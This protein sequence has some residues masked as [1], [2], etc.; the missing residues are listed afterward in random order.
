V[1]DFVAKQKSRDRRAGLPCVSDYVPAKSLD[2]ESVRSCVNSADGP[3]GSVTQTGIED[4]SRKLN[5]FLE[6]Q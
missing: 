3:Y 6:E 2:A 4:H 1:N 5:Q